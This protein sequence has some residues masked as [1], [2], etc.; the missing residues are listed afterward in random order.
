MVIKLPKA[1]EIQGGQ[2]EDGKYLAVFTSYEGPIKGRY[3]NSIHADFRIASGE[4]KGIS[5]RWA[6]VGIDPDRNKKLVALATALNGGVYNDSHDLDMYKGREIRIQ[7]ENVE[8]D[9]TVYSNVT[10]VRPAPGVEPIT[11]G[12]SGNDEDPDDWEE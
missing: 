5:V 11:G 6:W 3:G 10:G 8:K 7:V 2:V 12:S 9:G 4:S 1:S